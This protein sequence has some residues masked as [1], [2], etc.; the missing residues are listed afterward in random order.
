MSDIFREFVEL[1]PAAIEVPH[2]LDDEEAQLIRNEVT[3]S[4]ASWVVNAVAAELDN[5]REGLC[6]RRD[7][8]VEELHSIDLGIAEIDGIITPAASNIRLPKGSYE[9]IP[10]A[11]PA[12]EIFSRYKNLEKKDAIARLADENPFS[13]T[14]YNMEAELIPNGTVITGHGVRWNEA[15][16]HIIDTLFGV[17]EKSNFTRAMNHIS[18]HLVDDELLKSLA[19]KGVISD[20][21]VCAPYRRSDITRLASVQVEKPQEFIQYVLNHVRNFGMKSVGPLLAIAEL[22]KS[23]NS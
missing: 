20:A 15:N 22:Q 2:F 8:L 9:H 1:E 14:I 16:E 7:A 4:R 19:N 12:L 10:N 5:R 11:Q 13:L 21:V 6:S 23:Q 3:R 17:E 18:S